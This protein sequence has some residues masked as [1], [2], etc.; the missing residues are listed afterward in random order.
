[1]GVP[2]VSAQRDNLK[3][4]TKTLREAGVERVLETRPYCHAKAHPT[5]PDVMLGD[6]A[7]AGL[8][9][10]PEHLRPFVTFGGPLSAL[11]VHIES[12]VGPAKTSARAPRHLQQY[13]AWG[14][15]TASTSPTP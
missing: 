9:R 15:P 11:P 7:G 2:S 13:I 5:I 6:V 1:M 4:K 3:T 8:A 10:L 14:P 12:F